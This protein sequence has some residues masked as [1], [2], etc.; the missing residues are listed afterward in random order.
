MLVLGI[1]LRL[2]FVAFLGCYCWAKNHGTEFKRV[3]NHQRGVYHFTQSTFKVVL[4]Q[5]LFLTWV[6]GS[7]SHRVLW[8]HD[9]WHPVF[10]ESGFSVVTRKP[11]LEEGKLRLGRWREVILCL[12]AA[13]KAWLLSCHRRSQPGAQEPGI[14]TL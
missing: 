11:V 8:N 7:V 5:T 6:L 13:F 9:T 1:A 4:S 10:H 3:R 14:S 2:Y 12:L